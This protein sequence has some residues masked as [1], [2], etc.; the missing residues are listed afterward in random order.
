MG[1]YTETF[2]VYLQSH[3][4]PAS[5]TSEVFPHLKNR[6]FARFCDSEIGFETE[7]LF[8]IKFEAV[9]DS[10]IP[11]YEESVKALVESDSHIADPIRTTEF[12]N[13]KTKTSTT[14]LPYNVDTSK[15]S[16]VVST[17]DYTNTTTSS[18][19]TLAEAMSQSGFN[20]QIRD[21]EE[22]LINEFGN[23]FMRVY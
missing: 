15:P 9:A 21:M 2:Y 1:K 20:E 8:A 13:G 6:F 18:G 12:K 23:L 11:L 14:D 7:D 3:D 10:K 22:R 19:Y 5:F 4:Y 17:D 16:A